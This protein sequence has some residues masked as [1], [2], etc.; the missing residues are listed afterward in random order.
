MYLT[1]DKEYIY[2]FEISKSKFIS[3]LYPIQNFEEGLEY[4]KSIQKKHND[5]THNC[6]AIIGTPESNLYKYSDDGEPNQTAGLPIFKVLQNS[7]LFS[8]ICIVT[9]YFGGI[10]LGANGLVT[11]YTKAAAEVAKSAN[12]VSMKMSKIIKI[13]LDYNSY[14]LFAYKINS[15][16]H[17]IIN[18]DFD[19]GITLTL[20]IPSETYGEFTT[21]LSSITL[22]KGEHKLLE[23]KYIQYN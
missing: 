3:Y 4:L 20:A 11:N 17:L 13:I 15:L 22:G 21:F 6:Y 1:I 18:K 16:K 12:I 19:D 2:S 14:G 5:A 7:D 8:I 10:K 9:R 23:E